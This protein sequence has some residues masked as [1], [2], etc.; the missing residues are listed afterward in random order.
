MAL[1]LSL[2]FLTVPAGTEFPGTPQAFGNWFV[3]Y[4]QIT[5]LE[6]FNG[7]N[8]GPM[9]PDEDNRD[10]PWFQTD[11]GYNPISWK[12]WDGAEWVGL[13]FIMPSGTTAERPLNP[14]EGI[15][16]FDTD[17][18]VALIYERTMWRTLAGSPGD[19]KPVSRVLLADA[20][21][22]NPGWVELDEPTY[23]GRVLGVA[24]AGT[25]LTVRAQGD[26]VGEE[27]H[28]PV[29]AE[30]V[31]HTHTGGT[32]DG[33]NQDYGDPGQ[34]VLTSPTQSNGPQG[35]AMVSGQVTG[36][37]AVGAAFNVMQPTKFVWWLVKL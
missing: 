15:Q 5:G 19:I 21:T 16:F 12:S 29:L 9:T 36:E 26:S 30:L 3:D 2:E 25:A 4:C 34:F 31:A 28:T 24:G 33:S 35:N 10:K 7:V 6:N 20:L 22:V 32:V 14:I 17:I 27:N 8:F 18:N 1:N 11:E 13:P 23:G 37:T